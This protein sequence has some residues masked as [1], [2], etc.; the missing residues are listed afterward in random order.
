VES[1]EATR[2]KGLYFRGASG[3]RSSSA[4]RRFAAQDEGRF[5][6]RAFG[7]DAIWVMLRRL[8]ND[9]QQT[10]PARPSQRPQ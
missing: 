1:G 7:G 4:K 8:Y 6:G 9:R 5:R 10:R 2:R 3:G